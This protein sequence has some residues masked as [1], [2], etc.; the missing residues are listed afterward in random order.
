MWVF[1]TAR[2]SKNIQ[3]YSFFLKSVRLAGE[4]QSGGRIAV[5]EMTL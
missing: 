2:E 1:C 4:V 3:N 5:L